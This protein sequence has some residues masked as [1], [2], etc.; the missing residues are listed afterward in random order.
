MALEGKILTRLEPTIKLDEHKFDSF[1]EQ[2]GDNPGDANITRD[3]GVEFPLIIINGYQFNR[4]DI[5]SFEISL[6][7]FVPTIELT[8][9]DND[10]RFNVDSFPR[11]GDVITV[12][13]SARPK[14]DYKDIRIDFDITNVESPPV[15]V[16][17]RGSGGAKYSF[18]GEMKIPG[19]NAEQCK[20]YG[21]GTT[22]DHLE[23]IATDLK[24]GFASN[25]DTTD[26]E[27]NCVTTY[28]PIID[29]ITNLVKHS[30][31]NDDSFQTYC[32]DPFY[33]LTYVDLNIMIN[34]E[35]DFEDA[36]A[37]MN[38]DMNDTK[39][40]DAS[41]TTNE[42]ASTLILSTKSELE[43]SNLHIDKYSLKNNAGTIAKRNGYK[44]VLQ[45]FENDSDEGLVNFDIEPLSSNEMKDIA[46]PMKGRRDEE[47]YK[48]EIK[49]KYVGRRNSDPETS[50]THLNYN[51]AGIHNQ[52]NLQE[53]DKMTLEIEL[54]TW[55]PALY[56][57]QK[58]PVVIFHETDSQ[59]LV[60]TQVKATKEELGFEAQPESDPDL[61]T[62]G[63]AQ[64]VDEFLSG[65]YIIG[66]I[67]YTY[68][69]GA[70]RQ[71]LTLLRREWPSRLNNLQG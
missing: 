13:L 36:V 39:G 28:E 31:V 2:E 65:F 64:A 20:S 34:A 62:N 10:A 52:Q 46:E 7:D 38:D 67:R 40:P 12:R 45:Y 22:I 6:E 29:T 27:M 17:S 51:F 43:G 15:S 68:K 9:I 19:I 5:K 49:Y 58:I 26:D 70:I 33:Y 1:G 48:Q 56:R 24:I 35:D 11:D 23:K 4:A 21:K 57:Y 30:Y 14:D 42:M 25:V 47:R 71:H 44:R 63:S 32:I 69:G 60:D 41:N 3:L 54:S 55:N 61:P 53:L 66:S 16:I 18:A 37:A 8:V 50:N 59:V